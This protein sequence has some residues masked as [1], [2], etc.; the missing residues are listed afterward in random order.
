MG[1]THLTLPTV[2][3]PSSVI[4]ALQMGSP[5]HVVS[6]QNVISQ[7]RGKMVEEEMLAATKRS[8]AHL[9]TSENGGENSND[10]SSIGDQSNEVSAL[11][12]NS[13][14]PRYV[15]VV[16]QPNCVS[17]CLQ[18][19]RS[20]SSR[21]WRQCLVTPLPVSYCTDVFYIVSRTGHRK[22]KMIPRCELV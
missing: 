1:D 6:K 22:D 13:L 8:S 16:H 17:R 20:N 7:I 9:D 14:C 3:L 11:V 4:A 18:V 2:S 5:S 10:V 15:R 12:C 19:T 21:I